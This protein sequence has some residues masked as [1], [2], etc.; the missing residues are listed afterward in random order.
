VRFR[1]PLFQ[2]IRFAVPLMA[3]NTA[4]LKHASNVQGLRF[5]L[6]DAL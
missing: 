5:A 2:V 1:A 4:V 3:G 6:E